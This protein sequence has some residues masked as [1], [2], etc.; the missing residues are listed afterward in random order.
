MSVLAIDRQID[1]RGAAVLN[2]SY[3][4]HDRRRTICKGAL[5][6][7]CTHTS[8]V[9]GG[10]VRGDWRAELASLVGRAW[11]VTGDHASVANL[12][13]GCCRKVRRRE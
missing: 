8:H 10:E 12:L 11:A 3:R 4:L 1:I 2:L 13:G 7:Q 5:Q 9:G 6:R